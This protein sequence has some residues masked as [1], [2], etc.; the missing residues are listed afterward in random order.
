MVR[1]RQPSLSLEN[2]VSSPLDT[3]ITSVDDLLAEPASVRQGAL[4]MRGQTASTFRGPPCRGQ[5]PLLEASARAMADGTLE[6]AGQMGKNP[7]QGCANP[8]LNCADP[9]LSCANPWSNCADPRPAISA[10]AALPPPTV[11]RNRN[12]RTGSSLS[13]RFWSAK[14]PGRVPCFRGPRGAGC[15]RAQSRASKAC[16]RPKHAFKARDRAR[17]RVWASG[18]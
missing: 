5:R 16:E 12:R 2:N 15:V 17:A 10:P 11:R 14:T 3:V 13:T 9:Q 4:T 6:W 7:K 1:R 8:W 18:P